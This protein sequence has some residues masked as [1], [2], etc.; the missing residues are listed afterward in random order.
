MATPVCVE[1]LESDRCN[2]EIRI[3]S[4]PWGTE[5]ECECAGAVV[6]GG[7]DCNSAPI[8]D[9][10]TTYSVESVEIVAGVLYSA[11]V[12]FPVTSGGQPYAITFGDGGGLIETNLTL[13][14]VTSGCVSTTGPTGGGSPHAEGCESVSGMG[15]LV[16]HLHVLID[17]SAP[18][19]YTVSLS[20]GSC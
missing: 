10:D 11:H 20:A 4:G 16:A 14:A 15:A 9:L 3:C 6:E 18:F 13:Q 17:H 1:L 5:E 7:G 8:L 12:K 2:T 19:S